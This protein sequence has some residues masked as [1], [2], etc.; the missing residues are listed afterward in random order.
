LGNDPKNIISGASGRDGIFA[1]NP[2]SDTGM[3]QG[4]MA[5]GIRNKFG[6]PCLNL[7]RFGS[8]YTVMKKKLVTL[9]GLFDAPQ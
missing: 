7:R 3:Y 5:P 8:K 1:K 4:D 9:L 6:D 2:Q